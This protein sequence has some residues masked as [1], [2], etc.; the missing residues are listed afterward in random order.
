M[1]KTKSA[2]QAEDAA[3]AW[4]ARLNSAS[5]TEVQEQEFVQWLAASPL[6]QAAYIK[7]EDLWQRGEVLARVQNTQK[8]SWWQFTSWQQSA[9]GWAFA[10]SCLLAVS[11]SLFVYLNPHSNTYSYQT[12]IGEQQDIKLE[13]GTHI[14]L[15]T[16]SKLDVEF[17]RKKRTA[18]LT[19]GEVF[20][21]V[22]KDGRQFD[23]VTQFGV[24][25]V[26]GTRFSVRTLMTDAIVTVAEGRVALGKAIG[27]GEEFVP[28][29]VL[30][31]NERLS[32]E[33]ARAGETPEKV[34]ANAA[35]AWQK[36]Q[37]VFK[38]QRLN[39]VIA[40]LGRY[41]PETIRLAE[42]SQGDKEITAVIQ[43]TDLKTTL[44][45]LAQSL[46]M[47][48]EFDPSGKLITLVPTPSSIPP[49]AP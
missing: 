18:Y 3:I 44:N 39:D 20:F 28:S 16:N 11:F 2:M 40:E 25:R 8:I 46:N 48:L 26:V 1:S 33:T 23:I 47:S 45:T 19:Q 14:I 29:I 38:G 24:V 36:K 12:A 41:F 31:A 5:L 42:A 6:H 17:N 27:S 10:C 4:L 34:N 37:L 43:L 32:L 15:N 7:A 35:L 9:K 13:D 30:Q 49:I 21:A 22:K